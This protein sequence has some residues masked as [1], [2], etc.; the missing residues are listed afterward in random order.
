MSA[1]YREFTPS[2]RL[3]SAIECFWTGTIRQFDAVQR[4][5]PDGCADILFSRGA[6]GKPICKS[7]ER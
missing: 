1:N 7:L 4:V 2:M 5:L 3:K 6:S